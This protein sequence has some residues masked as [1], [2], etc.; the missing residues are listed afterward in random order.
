MATSTSGPGDSS[1][2][3]GG[4]TEPTP[5]EVELPMIE[6][7][8]P[9]EVVVVR[10]DAP[11]T[12][13]VAINPKTDEALVFC[14]LLLTIP[15]NYPMEIPRIEISVCR[16]LNQTELIAQLQETAKAALGNQMLFDIIEFA[17]DKAT[18]TDATPYESCT[19]CLS[20]FSEG[21]KAIRT[22]CFHYFHDSCLASWYQRKL[23]EHN[24]SLEN[25]NMYKAHTSFHFLCPVCRTEVDDSIDSILHLVQN[26]PAFQEF[27]SSP[28]EPLPTTHPPSLSGII[29][30][31]NVIIPSEELHIPKPEL[32]PVLI[33]TNVEAYGRNVS[34][35][36]IAQ[37]CGVPESQCRI[38]RKPK[39]KAI[40]GIITRPSH[41]DAKYTANYV[42]TN[43]TRINGQ[44]LGVQPLTHSVIK[45]HAPILD[46]YLNYSSTNYTTPSHTTR[47][48]TPPP[49]ATARPKT[50]PPRGSSHY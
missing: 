31:S 25:R 46:D 17:R 44:T 34:S 10:R 8:Y 3:S 24:K 9:A 20:P 11:V 13:R 16:G 47:P 39:S 42:S 19:I 41:Q 21:E 27:I 2:S 12:L 29:D 37:H 7:M 36:T 22:K 5:I 35:N 23:Q 32:P 43:R 1:S 15:I 14:E 18:Q 26:N 50:P 45:A 48:K 6:A 30:L 40:I 38:V 28:P 4:G 49:S 33:I